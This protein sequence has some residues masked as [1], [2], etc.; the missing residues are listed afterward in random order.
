MSFKKNNYE[1]TNNQQRR[2]NRHQLAMKTD[3]DRGC[4]D[5]YGN[6]HVMKG[7]TCEDDIMHSI[8]SFI[9]CIV[10]SFQIL[11]Q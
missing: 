9:D 10:W 1:E 4:I 11:C 2:L 6:Y 8:V 3:Q 5:L 7:K